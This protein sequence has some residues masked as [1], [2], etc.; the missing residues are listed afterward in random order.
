MSRSP[1]LISRSCSGDPRMS[2]RMQLA[3]VGFALGVLTVVVV[4]FVL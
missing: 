4:A 1:W 2:K 3:L